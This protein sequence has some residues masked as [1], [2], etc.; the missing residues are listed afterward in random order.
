MFNISKPKGSTDVSV[1]IMVI[2]SADGTPETGYTHAS[3]G[4][5]LWYRREGGAETSITEAALVAWNSAHADGGVEHGSDGRGRLDLPD[6]ACAVGSD[7]ADYVE[8]GGTITGMIVLGGVVTLTNPALELI[9]VQVIGTVG[10]TTTTLHVPGWSVYADDELDNELFMVKDVSANEW[11]PVWS[12][13]WAN[14]GS[15]LSVQT[16]PFTPEN[17]VDL[18]IRTGQ[19]QDPDVAAILLDTAEIGSAGDGLTDIPWNANLTTGI[20]DSM[21]DIGL[22]MEST[23][24]A[25]YT[26]NT[27]FTLTAGSA[28]DDAY[29]GAVIVIEDVTTAAQKAF[30]L[31]SD[32][33]GS[34]KQVTLVADPLPGFTFAATDKVTIMPAHPLIQAIK[35][36][37]DQFAFTVANQVDAN[38]LSVSSDGPAA[39]N[40]EAA[41]DGTGYAGGTI[42]QGVD[43]V[44]I[45]GST[46]AADNLEESTEA[47]ITGSA[48][49]GTLSVTQCTSDLTGYLNTELVG[50]TITFKSGVADGQQSDITAYAQT[51][52]LI[53]FTAIP[54]APANGDLF[55]IT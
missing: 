51:N 33:T 54:T 15:L 4:I 1:P 7:G 9:D 17:S 14:T 45:S 36:I 3:T 11:H 55:V 47:V 40:L 2:D 35:A 44:S 19:K 16:L 8:Y 12:T 31:V 21:E 28:D 20:A 27:V 49:T 25:T 43:V 32:Y 42:K 22:V 24:I 50:R 39:D 26:S 6:A 46:A 37:T 53:T 10:N 41:F 23:T 34:T 52:G 30:G 48:V 13:N 18:V 29:N 5:D 38:T